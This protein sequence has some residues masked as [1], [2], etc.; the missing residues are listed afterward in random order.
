MEFGRFAVAHAARKGKTAETFDF[1][2]F[3]HYCGKSRDGKRFRMKRLTARKKF[4]AK[5]HAFKQCR[6]PVIVYATNP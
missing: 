1:L 6:L 4:T 2:G 5:L 3:T